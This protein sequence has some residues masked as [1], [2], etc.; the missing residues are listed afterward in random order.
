M[1]KESSEA[2]TA[3]TLMKVKSSGAGAGS[4]LLKRSSGVGAGTVSFSRW[5]HSPGL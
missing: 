4:K 5:L 2:G 3:T 1:N